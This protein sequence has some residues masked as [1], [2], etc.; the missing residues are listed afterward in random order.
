MSFINRIVCIGALNGGDSY[1]FSSLRSNC[2]L[3]VFFLIRTFVR[4]IIERINSRVSLLLI[5]FI[6]APFRSYG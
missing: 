2:G 4:F 6:F 5:F 3:A 1:F